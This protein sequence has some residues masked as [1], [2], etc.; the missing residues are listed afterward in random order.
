MKQTTPVA[1]TCRWII[2]GAFLALAGCSQTLETRYAATRGKSINGISCFVDLL[3]ASG[4]KVDLW[5]GISPEMKEQYDTLII[6]QMAFDPRMRLEKHKLS[7]LVEYGDRLQV[8]MIVRD[9]DAEVEYWRQIKERTD[10]TEK[11][12]EAA[13]REYSQARAD[14]ESASSG[15]LDM[16]EELKFGLTT[17]NRI[18]S[19]SVKTVSYRVDEEI[20]NVEAN[21]PLHRRLVP[22][23]AAQ[24]LWNS[25]EDPLL[26]KEETSIGEYLVLSSAAPLLNGGLVDKGNR[27]LV[28]DF[29]GHIPES[30]HIAIA[31]STNWFDF[32][33]HRSPSMFDFVKVH[34]N[35]WVLCQAI[36][37]LLLFCWWK[38]PI[39]GRPKVALNVETARF[40]RHVE[41]FGR[42]LRRTQDTNYARQKIRDWQDNQNLRKHP[43]A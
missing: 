37:A 36:V 22:S 13:R 2:V 40:G 27:Q 38:F 7:E 34:P 20:R 3:R 19:P 21:W 28:E 32:S 5:P 33:G 6:V 43:D 12:L 1:K 26:I 15:K 16:D 11:Q 31:L 24:V 17:V 41:A 29:I 8:I 25:G 14:F 35:G 39:F 30:A 18:E 9:S 4:R 23:G 42:L 10:L